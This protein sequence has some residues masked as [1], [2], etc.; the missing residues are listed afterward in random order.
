ME[1]GYFFLTEAAVQFCL[2]HKSSMVMLTCVII[3]VNICRSNHEDTPIFSLSVQ[4][5]S[6]GVIACMEAG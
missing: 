3:W 6:R 5:T 1:S 4:G 2:S